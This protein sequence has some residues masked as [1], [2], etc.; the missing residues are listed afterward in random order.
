MTIG[1]YFLGNVFTNP[2]I[3]KNRHTR[4]LCQRTL[5]MATLVV[6]LVPLGCG[7]PV[8]VPALT[9]DEIPRFD[10][11]ANF[12]HLT[13]RLEPGDSIQIRYTFHPDMNQDVVI[14]PDGKIVAPL[15]GE[16]TASGMT[17]T[18]LQKFLAERSADKLRD[19]VV[20]VSVT[21]FAERTV[22]VGGEVQKPGTIP[23]RTG[24]SP[25]QAIIAVGGF[26]T[27]AQTDSIILVRAAG[28]DEKFIARKLNLAEVIADGV[29]EPIYLAPHD[30]VYVPRT[31]IAEANL[32]VKQHITDL[33]PFLVPSMGGATNVMRA[34]R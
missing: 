12:P 24:L 32:W 14:L 23:Y 29:R 30:L 28:P 11:S 15:V 9:S 13:Y 27:S 21:K 6:L 7:A 4:L 18:Q 33:L 22:Y 17:T 19:P 1:S 8:T 34:L 25:L 20:V 5:T 16:I 2:S 10:A 3:K 26:Q 31:P